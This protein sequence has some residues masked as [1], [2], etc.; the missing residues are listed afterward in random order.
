MMP[1]AAESLLPEIFRRTVREDGPLTDLLRAMEDFH[2]PTIDILGRFDSVL[3]P[4]RTPAPFVA[5]LARWLDLERLFDDP[6]DDYEVPEDG[7]NPISSGL[8][9]LRELVASASYLSQWRGTWRGLGRFLEVATGVSGFTVDEAVRGKDGEPLPFHMRI[10]VPRKAR[11]H[12]TLIERII[13]L[14]KPA[15]VTFELDFGT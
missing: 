7:R 8:G 14:E 4:Y 6:S 13:A 5:F 11:V 1:S 15:Y 3:D 2:A 9:R 12:R 10:G